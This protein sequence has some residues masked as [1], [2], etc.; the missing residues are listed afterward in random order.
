MRVGV[1]IDVFIQAAALGSQNRIFN[2]L[3]GIHDFGGTH[4]VHEIP[5]MVNDR[6]SFR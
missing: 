2:A 3:D 1:V 5:L 6:E 4:H